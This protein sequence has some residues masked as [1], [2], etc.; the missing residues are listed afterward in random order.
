MKKWNIFDTLKVVAS[1]LAF[2]GTVVSVIASKGNEQSL[3]EKIDDR[4]Q[5]ALSDS[6]A[7]DTQEG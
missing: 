7:A 2:A 1:G 3:E 6:Q 4:I 5:L